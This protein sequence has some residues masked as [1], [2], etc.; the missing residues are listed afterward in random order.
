MQNDNWKNPAFRSQFHE[1]CTKVGVDPLA[2][3][4]GFWAELLGI[5][6]FY[7][8]FGRYHLSIMQYYDLYCIFSVDL[9][10]MR[11]ILIISLNQDCWLLL[12][13][14]ELNLAFGYW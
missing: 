14:I 9:L 11:Y 1:M 5:G 6:D 3:N 13:T 12:M 10:F 7:Y 2:S 4:K 8:E